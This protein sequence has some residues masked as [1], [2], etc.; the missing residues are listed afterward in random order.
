MRRKSLAV[1]RAC[2]ASLLSASFIACIATAAQAQTTVDI[3]KI[4]CKQFV[5]LQVA[6]PDYL[7][8]WLSGYYHGQRKDT[9]VDVQKLKENAREVKSYCLYNGESTLMDAVEK[10]VLSQK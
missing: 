4:S 6:D 3:A 8:V 10:V 7:A 2:G 5:L 9:V 1:M